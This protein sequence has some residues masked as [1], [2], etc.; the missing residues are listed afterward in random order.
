MPNTTK[1]LIIPCFNE[2]LGI[3]KTLDEILVALQEFDDLE[4]IA[5]DDG[6]SDKTYSLIDKFP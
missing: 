1:S 2:A 4:I 5:V 3:E 6:S